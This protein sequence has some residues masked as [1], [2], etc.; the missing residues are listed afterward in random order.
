VIAAHAADLERA[1]AELAR[2]NEDL[3]QFAYAARHDLSEPLRCISGFADLL[4][5]RYHGSLD[6]DAER[7]STSSPPAPHR[8][9][10]HRTHATP[11][12]RPARLQPGHHPRALPLTPVDLREVLDTVLADLNGLIGDTGATVRIDTP[13]AGGDR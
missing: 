3:A 6:T 10:P 7:S 9:A 11:H 2:S 8:T 1:N 5:V 12:R 13:P 4:R